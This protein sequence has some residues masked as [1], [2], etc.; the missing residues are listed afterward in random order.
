MQ[1]AKSVNDGN[2]YLDLEKKLLPLASSLPPPRFGD[3]LAEHREQ[4]Q[5]FEQYINSRSVRKT[6]K[7][8]TVY[9]CLVGDFTEAQRRI[10][11]LT[12]DYLA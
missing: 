9:L 1:A 8:H 2:S 3:W 7:L 4:G 10:L 11:K 6:N 12:Q 5:S